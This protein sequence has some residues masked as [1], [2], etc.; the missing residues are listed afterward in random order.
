[1]RPSP[2]DDG[3]GAAARADLHHLDHGDAERQPAALEEAMGTRD[4]EGPRRPRLGIVDQADLGGRAAHVEGEHAIER[5]LPGDVAREDGAAHRP[6]F[7]EANGEADRRPDVGDAAAGEHDEERAAEARV[8]QTVLQVAQ[9][10]RHHRLDVGI[11][12]GGRETLVLAHLPARPRKR[13]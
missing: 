10:A 2:V 7:D 11:G 8:P 3:D 1:M 4:L 13:A 5:A 9:I 12:A 6:G